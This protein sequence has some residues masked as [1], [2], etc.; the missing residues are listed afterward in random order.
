MW[1]NWLSYPYNV[2]SSSVVNS[3]ILSRSSRAPFAVDY[4][5]FFS[6]DLHQACITA[7]SFGGFYVKFILFWDDSGFWSSHGRNFLGNGSFMEDNRY[8]KK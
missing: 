5:I 4:F 6:F 2:C 3:F 7:N 1:S 8:L